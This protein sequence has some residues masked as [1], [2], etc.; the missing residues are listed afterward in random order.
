MDMLTNELC[1]LVGNW[2]QTKT[3]QKQTDTKLDNVDTKSV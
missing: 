3:I 2:N 1:Y